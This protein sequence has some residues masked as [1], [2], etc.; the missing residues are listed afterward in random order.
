[1]FVVIDDLVRFAGLEKEGV[2]R[3]NRCR[4]ILVPD[5]AAPKVRLPHL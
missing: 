5:N 4:F 3:L 1:L 2:A